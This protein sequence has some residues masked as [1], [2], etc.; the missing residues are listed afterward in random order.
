MRQRINLPGGLDVRQQVLNH[1]TKVTVTTTR[2]AFE[3]ASLLETTSQPTAAL[4]ESLRRYESPRLRH[5]IQ[6]VIKPDEDSGSKRIRQPL[7]F[8]SVSSQSQRN[9]SDYCCCT[10]PMA[11]AAGAKAELDVLVSGADF[12]DFT[13]LSLQIWSNSLME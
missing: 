6:V 8:P 10:S 2:R 11:H 3:P 1:P 12:M 9:N 13:V 7:P 5:C 4:P